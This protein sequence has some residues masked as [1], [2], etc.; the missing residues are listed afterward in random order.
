MRTHGL[1]HIHLAVADLDRSE[2]FYQEVFGAE[3]RFSVGADLVFLRTQG[4]QDL[5]ALH[6][7]AA[8]RGVAGRSGGIGHFGFQLLRPADLAAAARVVEAAGGSVH[9]RG[10]HR[11]ASHVDT[12][13]LLVTDLDGYVI[14]LLARD[15]VSET[16]LELAAR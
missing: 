15:P 4:G 7:N 5:I 1:S 2:R 16:V 11:N 3:R 10:T 8:D 14:E 6:A 13:Y 9:E 12:A